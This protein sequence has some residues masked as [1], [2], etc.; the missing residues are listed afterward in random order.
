M[1]SLEGI[2]VFGRRE[3]AQK[4]C[5]CVGWRTIRPSRKQ[6]TICEAC[7]KVTRMEQTKLKDFSPGL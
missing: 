6:E 7:E 3:E 5:R 2:N 1:F 4:L